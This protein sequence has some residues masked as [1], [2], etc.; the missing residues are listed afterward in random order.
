[1][2][3]NSFMRAGLAVAIMVIAPTTLMAGKCFV[4]VHGHRTA[5]PTHTQIYNGQV[6]NCCGDDSS[7]WFVDGSLSNS[8]FIGD[9]SIAGAVTPYSQ[10]DSSKNRYFVVSWNPLNYYWVGAVEVAHQI[11]RALAGGSA[12][13]DG[14][15]K[16]C[17]ATDDVYIVSHSMGGPTTDYILG[18]GATTDPNYNSCTTTSGW[19]M[20]PGFN[21]E[22]VNPG[23]DADT[24]NNKYCGNFA[25]IRNNTRLKRHI[26][27]QGAHRGTEVANA[28]CGVGP[29]D[30]AASVMAWLV[31]MF[32]STTCD[33]GTMSLTTGYS[34]HQYMNSPAKT[35]RLIVGYEAIVGP[36]ASLCGEDD[37]VLEYGSTLASNTADITATCFN[38][39]SLPLNTA[40]ME[41]AG[42]A[43]CDQS[44]EDHDEGRNGNDK[45]TRKAAKGGNTLG[46]CWSGDPAHGTT[47]RS[48]MSSAQMVRCAFGDGTC[49]G[50]GSY[51]LNSAR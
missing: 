44:H 26:S 35:T 16:Y 7:Y 12:N 34:S 15:G 1:M 27:L 22:T 39:T 49:A 14:R 32:S 36:S 3:L 45:D 47:V 5:K 29:Y 10:T 30:G 2:H 17:L 9:G 31:G 48:S 25:A 6:D 21:D 19:V 4:F 37:G 28:I 23:F 20:G 11:N 41:S 42:I 43:N 38:T 51:S 46:S 13:G 33:P 8:D 24:T 50:S 18:N 40:K